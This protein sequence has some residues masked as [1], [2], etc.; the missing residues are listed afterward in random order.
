MK[1]GAIR[2]GSGP[3]EQEAKELD[4]EPDSR[5]Q[6][7]RRNRLAPGKWAVW[8]YVVGCVVAKI[9]V[10]IVRR[11]SR[12]TR[13]RIPR[14]LPIGAL[15]LAGCGD[16]TEPPA[17]RP[18]AVAVTPFHTE[19]PALGQTVQLTAEVRDQ[20]GRVMT[21]V[22]LTWS[23]STAAV[24]SVE[25][26]G[27]VTAASNG[28]TTITASAGAASATATVTVAQVVASVAVTPAADTV[29]EADTLR[30]AA[31]AADANGHEVTGTAIAWASADTLVAVVDG[32]G[33]VTGVAVGRVLVEASTTSGVAGQAEIEVVPPVASA[34]S[35]TPDSV[36]LV[37]LGASARLSAEVLDQVGRVMEGAAVA[38]TSGDTTVAVVDSA[39][40]VTAVGSGTTRVTVAA[41]RAARD[42]VVTVMQSV[43]SIIMSPPA[44]MIGPSDT[45]RLAAE[46][47]DEN[48]HTAAGVEFAWS[49]SDTAVA[50]VDASGLV[51]GLKEGMATITAQVGDTQGTSEITVENPDRAA[52]VALFHATGGPNWR[53][54]DNWLTDAPLSEWY[55]VEIGPGGRVGA[56]EM[57]G[58][59]L[60][61]PLPPELGKLTSLAAL[62]LPRNA[63]TGAIPPEL[64][65]LL[66]LRTLNLSVNDLTGQIPPELGRLTRL[67]ELSLRSNALT[68]PIPSGLGNLAGLRWLY[69]SRNG[70]TGPIPPE[71]GNLTN[72]SELGLSNNALTGPI[73]RWLGNLVT[74]RGLGLGGN[75][76]T[77]SIPLELGNLLSL[78]WL[79]LGGGN[80]LT[81]PVPDWL[82]NLVSLESLDLGGNALTGPIPPELGNLASLREL[83]L[84]HNDLNGPIPPELGSLSSLT[85][86]NLSINDLTGPI[87][88]E[89]GN[90][91][92]LERKL[93]L[94]SNALSGPIPPELGNLVSLKWLDLGINALTGSIPAELGNLVSLETGLRLG[95]N[96]LTGPVPP[97]LG[98]LV[99]L[100]RLH[101]AANGL[102]GPI[103]PEL[104]NLVRLEDLYIPGNAMTGPIPPEL[105]DLTSL[106]YLTLSNN[107]LAGPIPPEL[108]NLVS[109][110]ALDVGGNPHLC[111]P[112]DPRLERWL[113][114]R[115]VHPL[116]C[117]PDPS[118]Q[119]LPRALMRE[120]GNGLSLALPDD[121]RDPSTVTVSDPSV[122][123]A[124]VSDGW[125]EL[126]PRGRGSAEVR[127]VPSGEGTPA[128]A[129]VV[130]RAPVGTFGIDIVLD[131]PA[132]LGYEE[133]MTLAADWWS[134]A[135][136]GTEWPDSR[137]CER[138]DLSVT[139]LADELLIQAGSADFSG[140]PKSSVF[141]GS[142]HVP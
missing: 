53:R 107:D 27:L 36:V 50:T 85:Y 37:A 40:V 64:G 103:P 56:V 141:H 25:A 34:V 11:M 32:A 30:L 140:T 29:V 60:T 133:A 22:A 131:Q 94:A 105:G 1:T 76:L 14:V 132:P 79:D 89:L 71:L 101:L 17:P 3:G 15:A 121:L 74:L 126:A 97:E 80:T 119:L 13:A 26:S 111:V 42:V 134:S 10:T 82:G 102:T 129:G 61:G 63:L 7:P 39:G 66:G 16:T 142:Y 72:L 31:L 73:P 83:I 62:Y 78:R 67:S 48:G 47:F 65:N 114:Q 52:L 127:V 59:G 33:L 99:S 123:V 138:L 124:S 45:L 57:Y 43:R 98:N 86:L 28:A 120:D 35:V 2:R 122:V 23:S 137:P 21:G 49:S 88:P 77:G 41:G 92:R 128:V 135:L 9:I 110:M 46:A 6:T 12:L 38:W 136:D 20:D 75:A 69:L 130:V 81:G 18:A 91:V 54:R 108:V 24:A 5:I 109:L 112:A 87:P 4:G 104:G 90:L 113:T 68:G 100:R 117:P 95:S 93:D 8:L 96:D 70:L 19:I 106:R 125:L 139:A 115:G 118:V 84:A 44:H 51:T 116:R 58:N 55:G